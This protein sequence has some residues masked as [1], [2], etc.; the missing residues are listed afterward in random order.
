MLFYLRMTNKEY[1]LKKIIGF[2][3]YIVISLIP[4]MHIIFVVER[5][6]FDNIYI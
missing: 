2:L 4:Y 6:T 1:A 5:F 3:K